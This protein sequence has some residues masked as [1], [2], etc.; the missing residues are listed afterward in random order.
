MK[1]WYIIH[2]YSGYEKQVIRSQNDRI[3]R[4]AEADSFGEVHVPN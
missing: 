2:A 3:K 4:S 1:R